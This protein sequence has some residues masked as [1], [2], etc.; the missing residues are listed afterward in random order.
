METLRLLNGGKKVSE[1]AKE[2]NLVESTIYTHCF[3]LIVNNQ[4]S[5]SD[6]ISGETIHK[7][8]NAVNNTSEPSV[9]AI[10]E[11][12]PELSYEEIRCVLAESRDKEK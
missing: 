12:L 9:K 6:I 8:I 7:I 10:K 4:L 5:S 11:S 3:R 1:I 2:R